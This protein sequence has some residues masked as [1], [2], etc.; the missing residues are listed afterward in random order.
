MIFLVQRKWFT[1]QS[2]IGQL[3]ID[4]EFECFTLEPRKDQSRGKPYCIPTGTYPVQLLPSIRFQMLT[5][6]ILDVPDFDAIEIH[7]GNYPNDTHGC[8]LVGKSRG[9]DAV[10][11]SRDAFKALMAKLPPR[12]EITYSDEP[13]PMLVKT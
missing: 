9:R 4:G 7:P 12:F 3:S 5:P 11:E 13:A 1:D 10:L 6:H 2:S 8:T